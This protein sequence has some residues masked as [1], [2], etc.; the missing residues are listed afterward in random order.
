M[1]CPSGSRPWALAF[2]LIVLA[3]CAGAVSTQRVAMT[4]GGT[5]PLLRTDG[6]PGPIAVV[7]LGTPFAG[8]EAR[9][10]AVIAA[11]FEGAR[12]IYRF[13]FE[14]MPREAGASA[15]FVLAFAPPGARPSGAG[16]CRGEGSLGAERRSDGL[17]V[18]GVG[19]LGARRV[20]EAR[21][22][23]GPLTGPDDPAFRQLIR[24]LA[25]ALVDERAATG[26]D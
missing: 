7:R 15:Y 1:P 8:A 3:G 25:R 20:A 11:A 5:V 21:G 4:S 12:P 26:D 16:L 9:T 14:V 19:C 10:D 6:G 17:E 18:L 24:Q 13:D 2:A 22:R 23:A